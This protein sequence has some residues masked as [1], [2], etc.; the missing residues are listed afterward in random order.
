MSSPLTVSPCSPRIMYSAVVKFKVDDYNNRKNLG[1][2]T[3][4]RSPIF[5]VGGYEWTIQYYPDGLTEETEGHA[6]VALELMSENDALAVLGLTFA[7]AAD[8]TPWAEWPTMA[9]LNRGNQFL[10]RWPEVNGQVF[11]QMALVQNDCLEIQCYINVLRPNQLLKDGSLTEVEVPASDMAQDLGKLLE[12]QETADVRF[13]VEQEI[14]SAHKVIL[15]AR[16]PVFNKQ[17]CGEMRE[18]D[19]DCIVVHDMQAVVFRSLLHFIYTD[20]LIDMSDVD[21]HEQK[22]LTRH[23]L[24]AADRYCMPRLKN[25]CESILCKCLD[26]EGLLVTVA[27]AE[28]HQCR[29]LLTAC[30]ELLVIESMKSEVIAN[31]WHEALK[32]NHPDVATEVGKALEKAH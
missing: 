24:V 27:L 29:K 25:I 28:Q 9:V 10:F 21:V 14:F 32:D 22:E 17:L 8:R 3:F 2:A 19:T 13:K 7:G 16:S 12:D 26:A 4:I 15:A 11:E 18:K 20:S 30:V 6:S 23:L 31:H 5:T 1:Y